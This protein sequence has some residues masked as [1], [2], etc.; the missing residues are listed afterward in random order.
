VW[1][2]QPPKGPP[3]DTAGA[4]SHHAVRGETCDVQPLLQIEREIELPGARED[5]LFLSLEFFFCQDSLF[6][7]FIELGQIVIQVARHRRMFTCCGVAGGGR[8]G[9]RGIGLFEFCRGER[10][11][12]D[13]GTGVARTPNGFLGGEF[14]HLQL[15][16]KLGAV[17]LCIG[18]DFVPH[19]VGVASQGGPRGARQGESVFSDGGDLRR[20]RFG[21][22]NSGA[23]EQHDA[24]RESGE[25]PA[26]GS[27]FHARHNS[28]PEDQVKIE[29]R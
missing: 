25:N 27:G 23:A 26:E 21:V 15:L 6:A 16:A 7:K 10:F 20:N 28:R 22:G 19:H 1:K 5:F 29:V 14:D 13:R 4:A 18:F 24:D 8:R 2:R 9:W 11:E 12:D 17:F 3:K